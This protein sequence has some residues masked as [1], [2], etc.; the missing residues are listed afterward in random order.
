MIVCQSSFRSSMSHCLSIHSIILKIAMRMTLV[1]VLLTQQ[2]Q[3]NN[4]LHVLNFITMAYG[5]W[6]P[7]HTMTCHSM[8]KV[9]SSKF[10]LLR[11][12]HHCTLQQGSTRLTMVWVQWSTLFHLVICSVRSSWQH[13]AYFEMKLNTNCICG[14]RNPGTNADLTSTQ[15]EENLP[16]W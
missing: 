10:V 2:S 4:G 14:S 13:G 1:C 16:R 9:S 6:M 15:Q 5:Q 3:N 12:R 11:H 8:R 7:S